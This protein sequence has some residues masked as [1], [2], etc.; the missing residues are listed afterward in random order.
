MTRPVR[1]ESNRWLGDK[2]SMAVHDLDNPRDLCA[3]DDLISS[4]K[5][6]AFGPDLLAEARNRCFHP[7][8][9]CATDTE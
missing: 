9:N 4:E 8:P 5:F 1:F 2:R 7:C 6:L 3:I